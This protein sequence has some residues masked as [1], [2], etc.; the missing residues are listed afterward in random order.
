[1]CC[2]N[3]AAGFELLQKPYSVEQ[4]S[5]ALHRVAR[6]RKASANES[7]GG[8]RE[9]PIASEGTRK[10]NLLISLPLSGHG[11]IRSEVEIAREKTLREEAAEL[12]KSTRR[13][14][15]AVEPP[16]PSLSSPIRK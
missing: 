7:D 9:A 15:D 4:L 14:G 5:R 11:Q 16:P 2:P 8:V 12:S 1:M 3:T 13:I 6:R 10:G